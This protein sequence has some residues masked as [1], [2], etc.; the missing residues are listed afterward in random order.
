MDP[1]VDVAADEA[2]AD[3]HVEDV[4][5]TVIQHWDFA[6]CP[7]G[8]GG[9]TLGHSELTSMSWECGTPGAGPGGDHG[10]DGSVWATRLHSDYLDF[11][12][13]A[14]TSP[15]VDLSAVTGPVTLSFWHWYDF[16]YCTSSC[17]ADNPSSCA[18]DGGN[19]EVYDGMSWVMVVPSGAYPG[20]LRFFDSYYVHPLRGAP[21][22]NADG[23]ESTWL[24]ATFD[25]TSYANAGFQVRFVFGSDSGVHED[26]WYIDDVMLTTP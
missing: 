25:V 5:G 21:G 9:I 12:W 10:G 23:T 15:A 8:W 20:T 2:P 26:G 22:Y 14:L 13:S 24:L 11:E 4:G 17:G 3:T 19:V 1:P 6:I 16:E 18:L 7:A